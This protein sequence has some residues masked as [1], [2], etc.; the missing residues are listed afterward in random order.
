VKILFI[1][2]VVGKPGRRMV[3]AMLPGLRRELGADLVIANGENSAGGFGITRE[4]F[5]DLVGAGV[6]VVT[7]GNHTWQ[8]REV[9]GLLDAEPRLLRPANYPPGTP[10]RGGAV[11]R[12]GGNRPG[13]AAVGVAVL[14]LEGR[15]FMQPL[16]SPFEVGREE[17]ARLRDE[18]AVIV[19]DF[20][21]E[22]TS[23]KIALG[24]HLDGR[25][26]AV[27]GTHTHVQTADERVLPGGTAFITDVG[28]TGPRDSIIGMGREEVLQRFLTLLPARFEV[29]GGPTQLNAVLIDVDEHTG[30][31]RGIE[32]V[33]RVLE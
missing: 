11:F 7:G 22:A 15:V 9:S 12:T 13:A 33:R 17:I 19:V 26:S 29:A 1:G 5:E 30:R 16:L 21:A 18:A 32:R 25:A 27:V 2:D 24:W 8:A 20:H 4:T 31:A 3:A 6:D 23:E 28:M 10:G 14:N